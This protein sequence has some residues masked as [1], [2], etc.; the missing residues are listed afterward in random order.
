MLASQQVVARVVANLVAANTAAGARVYSDRFHPVA[1]FPAVKVVVIDEDMA[2]D[3]DGDDITFPAVRLHRLQ[4]ELRADVEAATGLDAA[5]S[6]L[7]VQLLRALEGTVAA[8]TLQPLPGCFVESKG[9]RYQAASEGQAAQGLAT[10][11]CEV[12]FRTKSNDPETLI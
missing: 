1:T 4:L 2:A 11:R 12:Q 9:V 6:A 5:M 10:V 8:A 7:V 3:E